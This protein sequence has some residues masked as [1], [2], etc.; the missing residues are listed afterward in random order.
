MRRFDKEER[1]HRVCEEVFACGYSIQQYFEDQGHDK[2]TVVYAEEQFDDLARLL[3]LDL[4]ING[5]AP[6]RKFVSPQEFSLPFCTEAHFGSI[7]FNSMYFC[8]L[9]KGDTVFIIKPSV[10]PKLEA[11]FKNLGLHVLH[12][13]REIP[14]M[15]SWALY[16]KPLLYFRHV[17]PDV[18]IA[19]CQLPAFPSQAYSVNEQAIVDGKRDTAKIIE[20]LQQNGEAPEALSGFGYSKG[21]LLDMLSVPGSSYDADNVRR[22]ADK[23]GRVT[24]AGGHRVTLGQPKEAKRNIFLVGDSA[25]FG[26]GAPDECTIASQLQAMLNGRNGGAGIT[27]HNYGAFLTS[28]LD[29]LY[30]TLGS[31]ALRPGDIVLVFAPPATKFFPHI[32]LRNL[33][34]RPHA[35]GE[36]FIDRLT[37]NQE[38]YAQIA[39]GL[40]EEL[41]H[42]GFFSAAQGADCPDMPVAAKKS[43]GIPE[44]AYYRPPEAPEAPGALEASGALEAP[45]APETSGVSEAPEAPAP[46]VGPNRKALGEYRA[47][48]EKTRELTIGPIGSIV[49]NCDPFTLGHRFLVEYAASRV[50]YLYLFV[51]EGPGSLFPFKDRFDLAVAGISDLPNVTVL[52]SGPFVISS[53]AFSDCLNP[54]EIQA[55]IGDSLQDVELFAKDIAPVMDISARFAGDEPSDLIA[56]QYNDAMRQ[57]LSCYGIAFETVRR[58]EVDGLPISAGRVQELLAS[59]DFKE[60]ARLVPKTTLEYLKKKSLESAAYDILNTL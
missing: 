56:Q 50:K 30:T 23:K 54:S 53:P 26:V 7:E 39:K 59:Q 33:F 55:R 18:L 5:R 3:L 19:T 11:Y 42:K 52:P 10:D 57:I 15:L 12:A 25:V 58:K 13:S 46:S 45:G 38:G 14:K 21:E 35:Y 51:V 9:T 37:Y 32:N 44:V 2:V 31:L 16:V 27:V 20:S 47:F 28:C 40:F 43:F 29:D 49:M 8:D 41:G 1:L 4:R 48:L 34:Q 24:I 17:R 60:I 36:V 6:G 22:Y